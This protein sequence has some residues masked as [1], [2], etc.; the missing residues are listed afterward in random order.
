[1]NFFRSCRY[2]TGPI[3]KTKIGIEHI[4]E[5]GIFKGMKFCLGGKS[6]KSFSNEYILFSLLVLVSQ[7][8]RFELNSW[9]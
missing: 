8:L 4:F 2:N 7:F 3:S 6:F 5:I 1:M 9:N